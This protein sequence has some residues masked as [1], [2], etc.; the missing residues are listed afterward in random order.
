MRHECTDGRARRADGWL[1]N[2]DLDD[3]VT[4]R[5]RISIELL[6]IFF[7]RGDCCH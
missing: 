7:N 6:R 2:S 4:D 1:D 5:Q 3:I